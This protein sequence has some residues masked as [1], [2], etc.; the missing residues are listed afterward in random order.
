MPLT[1]LLGKLAASIM[2]GGGKMAA[3]ISNGGRGGNSWVTTA[4][5][6]LTAL[7]LITP[8]VAMQFSDEVNWTVSDFAFAGGILVA[9]GVTYE[10][11]ARIGGLAYQVAAA[12]ALGAGVLT[13]WVTG[14][15]G[16]IG[17]EGNP[18]NLLYL[19]VVALAI[20]GALIAR[21]RAEPM[22]WAMSVV[23]F[24]QVL[25]PAIAYNSVADPRSDVLSP[26]VFAAT[27][28]LTAMWIASAWLFR[29]AARD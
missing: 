19:A 26:E 21:G 9:C 7:I 13:V 20:A 12:L 1:A 3:Q 29:K 14:A 28:F 17:D 8:L 11:A 5:I 2:P 6:S 24:G 16:I 15:V 10:L 22:S 27:G 23:A 4:W 25:V 18:A